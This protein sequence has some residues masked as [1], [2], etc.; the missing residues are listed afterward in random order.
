[1]HTSELCSVKFNLSLILD[2]VL[3]SISTYHIEQKS[4]PYADNLTMSGPWG[5]LSKKSH[6]YAIVSIFSFCDSD[7]LSVNASYLNKLQSKSSTVAVFV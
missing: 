1:M 6:P 4:P 7:N 3:S 5:K 2:M